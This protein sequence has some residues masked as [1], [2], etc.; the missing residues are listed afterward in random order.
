M[1]FGH[2]E[3]ARFPHD[4]S[5][6]TRSDD[7]AEYRDQAEQ[8]IKDM[9]ERSA[10]KRAVTPLQDKSADKRDIREDVV[11]RLSLSGEKRKSSQNAR[12]VTG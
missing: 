9:L 1:P 3:I 4:I 2:A 7:I 11:S 10:R 12:M 5:T 8:G 6:Q